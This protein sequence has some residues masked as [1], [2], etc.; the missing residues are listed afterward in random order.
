MERAQER[1]GKRD[2]LLVGNLVTED[3]DTRGWGFRTRQMTRL[4][5][6]LSELLD[7][8]N[9]DELRALCGSLGIQVRKKL[10]CVLVRIH[11]RVCVS[12]ARTWPSI[13]TD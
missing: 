9:V 8:H 4:E 13:L 12:C 5:I 1:G 6:G 11:C 10:G 2:L 7:L 3:P